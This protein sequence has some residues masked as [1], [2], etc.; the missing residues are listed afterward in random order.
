MNIYGLMVL[1]A[2]A[3][4][5]GALGAVYWRLRV[6]YQET[7]SRAKAEQVTQCQRPSTWNFDAVEEWMGAGEKQGHCATCQR[8]KWSGEKCGYF[9]DDTELE[10]AQIYAEEGL[11]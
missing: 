6:G 5:C 2:V 9:V 11:T 10:T 7:M 8:W 3:L 4:T 1:G